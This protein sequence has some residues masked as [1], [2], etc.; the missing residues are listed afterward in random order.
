MSFEVAFLVEAVDYEFCVGWEAFESG[1][2]FGKRGL[3]WVS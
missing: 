1:W 2:E 3:K